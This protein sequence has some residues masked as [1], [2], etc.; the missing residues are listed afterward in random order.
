MM[1]V[2]VLEE[3]L[4]GFG[5]IYVYKIMS[6]LPSIPMFICTYMCIHKYMYMCI[7]I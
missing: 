6:L 5:N 2:C 7:H 3:P 4:R 1:T